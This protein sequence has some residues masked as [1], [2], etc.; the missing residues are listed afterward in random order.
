MK[1]VLVTGATGFIGRHNLPL[2]LDKDYEVHAVSSK[3]QTVN[4]T[5]VQ[6]HQADLLNSEQVLNL[7]ASVRPTHLLHFAWYLVPGKSYT[8]PDNYRWVQASFELLQA[9]ARQGGQRVVMAGSCAEYDWRYGFC[10]EDRTPLAPASPYGA[11]KHALQ[12]MFNAFTQQTELSG[13]WGRQF[14]LYG[15]HEYSVR[16]VAS[17]ICSILKN[18]PARCSHGNQIRDFLYVE[19]V[20]DAFVTLLESDVSGPINIGSGHPYTLKEIIY[21]IAQKLG[22]EDLIQLGV[23]PTSP[24]EAPMVVA[25][26][27]RLSKKLGWQPQYDLDQGL[28]QTINWWKNELK[29]G[30]LRAV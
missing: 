2:L 24:D 28:E 14:F 22:R 7:I 23:I 29:N 21:K 12:T 27:S 6:W 11:C 13:A 10:S 18:Q 25:D 16:L 20:A 5:N 9:F 17:V 26:V 8:S 15:P 3:P 19:D 30:G 4:Q 1:K